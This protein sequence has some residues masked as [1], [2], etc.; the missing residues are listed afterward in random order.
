M[1]MQGWVDWDGRSRGRKKRRERLVD[2]VDV[3]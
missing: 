3:G 2:Q 1:E